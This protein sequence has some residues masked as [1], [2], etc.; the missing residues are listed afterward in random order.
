[1][2]VLY[3]YACQI[4]YTSLYFDILGSKMFGF[5]FY[6]R[7]YLLGVYPSMFTEVIQTCL[8][9]YIYLYIYSTLMYVIVCLC[10]SVSGFRRYWCMICSHAAHSSGKS[11][12]LLMSNCRYRSKNISVNL[13][14]FW[15]IG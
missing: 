2:Y 6:T 11:N 9:I 10:I 12:T 8:F 3:V 7:I 15:N 4:P 1:M 14:H 13:I 5:K